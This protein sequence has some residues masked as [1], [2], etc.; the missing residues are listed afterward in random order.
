MPSG[1][2]TKSNYKREAVVSQPPLSYNTA[3]LKVPYVK[4]VLKVLDNSHIVVYYSST[5]SN[6]GQ[7][8]YYYR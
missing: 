1:R 3:V 6:E 5:K 4:L 2:R 8:K 7:T